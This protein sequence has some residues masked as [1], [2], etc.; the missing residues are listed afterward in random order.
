MRAV[1]AA[2]AA[3]DAATIVLPKRGSLHQILE[4]CT[5][6]MI[7]YIVLLFVLVPCEPFG[8]EKENVSCILMRA[9][10]VSSW[11]VSFFLSCFI[12]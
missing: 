9:S 8:E 10:P 5:L 3:A 1:A 7:S 6:N 2:A 12:K 11:T 4:A